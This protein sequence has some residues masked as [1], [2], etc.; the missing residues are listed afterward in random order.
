M[1]LKKHLRKMLESHLQEPHSHGVQQQQESAVAV[2]VAHQLEHQLEVE[3]E[4][5]HGQF[6]GCIFFC[7]RYTKRKFATLGKQT[8][9]G[10]NFLSGRV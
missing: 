4:V 8:G 6:G 10:C 3:R 5:G 2:E 1:A 7:R 9:L